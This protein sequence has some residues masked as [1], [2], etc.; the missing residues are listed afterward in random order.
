MNI[1]EWIIWICMWE[2]FKIYLER[3]VLLNELINVE[4]I[5]GLREY[6]VVE[7]YG[8]NIIFFYD[9]K[10]SIYKFI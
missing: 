9:K 3:I 10:F 2:E 1:K 7:L 5:I 6:I 4:R 8:F